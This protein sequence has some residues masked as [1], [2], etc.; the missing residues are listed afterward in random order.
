MRKQLCLVAA[1]S[2]IMASTAFEASGFS[3]LKS[4]GSD[5]AAGANSPG[6][7]ARSAPRSLGWMPLEQGWRMLVAFDAMGA[8]QSLPLVACSPFVSALCGDEN[9]LGRAAGKPARPFSGGTN[10]CPR[11]DSG[12]IGGELRLVNGVTLSGKFD[13]EFARG[14]QTYAGTGTIRYTW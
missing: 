8:T 12:E 11:N 13:G 7:R 4:G 9:N 1:L 5:G 14:S 3:N 6:M 2:A 10:E